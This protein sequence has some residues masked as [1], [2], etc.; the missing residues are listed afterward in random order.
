MTSN[1]PGIAE[2]TSLFEKLNNCKIKSVAL[3]LTDE[4]VTSHVKT[5]T[6]GFPLNG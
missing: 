6:N 4:Y 2:M 3:S 5:Y 1:E